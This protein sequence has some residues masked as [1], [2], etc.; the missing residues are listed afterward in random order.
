M[1]NTEKPQNLSYAQSAT[2]RNR[3][4]ANEN[5]MAFMHGKNGYIFV[6]CDAN[7]KAGGH[8]I[9][10]LAAD[11]IVN[12]FNHQYFTN[13]YQALRNALIFA[14]RRVAF[15]ASFNKV[16]G[17]KGM[18]CDV[19]LIRENALYFATVGQSNLRLFSEEQFQ[20]VEEAF[21]YT[22]FRHEDNESLYEKDDHAVNSI[23]IAASIQ[24]K[25]CTQAVT[26]ENNDC[27]IFASNALANAL[28]E[29]Q[30]KAVLED[31]E[32]GLQK[33]ADRLL[34][35]ASEKYNG[36]M[37]L[38]LLQFK[39][40]RYYGRHSS[41]DYFDSFYNKLFKI[42]TS[43]LIFIV[44]IVLIIA[45]VAISLIETNPQTKNHAVFHT[46][47]SME[48]GLLLVAM[49]APKT[50][51]YQPPVA[52]STFLYQAEWGESLWLLANRFNLSLSELK[53][54]NNWGDN[55]LYVT[56]KLKIPVT[57][58]HTVSANESLDAIAEKYN[59]DK[60]LIMKANQFNVDSRLR[61]GQL[62]VIPKP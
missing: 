3:Y 18:S 60:Q 32:A 4:T 38:M 51:S 13:P 42:I 11:S 30:V 45:G 28:E 53:T 29:S 6:L 26:P 31:K 17:G 15:Y 56:Q 7:N 21:P 34:Q 10:Q 48:S 36:N 52:D 50:F 27:F 2:P 20:I 58:I 23:G 46:G 55:K 39:N 8:R 24:F 57:A 40:M 35:K 61:S 41:S 62:L 33:K 14:N 1:Y 22:K 9:A 59:V 5:A 12:F 16:L 44:L 37:N 43:R 47:S 19:V 54:Y 25:V 49:P